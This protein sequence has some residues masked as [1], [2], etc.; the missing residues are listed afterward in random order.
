MQERT[1]DRTKVQKPIV[2]EV[3][4][5][6]L[7]VVVADEAGYRFLAVKLPAFAIDGHTYNSVENARIAASE[8]MR[9]NDLDAA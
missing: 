9:Q 6:P 2:I 5:E 8:A 4:G 1:F 7:G 3:G